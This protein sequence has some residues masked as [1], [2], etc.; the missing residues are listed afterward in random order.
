MAV[1][2]AVP[3]GFPDLD[4]S[5]PGGGWPR[6]GL[7]EIL[8][9]HL[10]IGE[11]YLLLP[12]LARLTHQPSARW[13]AWIAPPFQPFA[14]AL[15]AHGLK[16]ER[17]LIAR[18]DSPESSTRPDSRSSKT[19][20]D[21]YTPSQAHTA[22]RDTSERPHSPLWAFEQALGSNACDVGLTWLQR[23]HPREIRRLQ[24]AAERGRS[25]GFLFRSASAAQEASSAALRVLLQ[26][27]AQGACITLLKSRGGLRGAINVS[28][29]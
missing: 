21:S 8:T 11:L 29:T 5:L 20:A 16:L 6:V 4:R 24:L 3:T 13:C 12:A 26:P 22:S 15:T 23:A 25:L 27:T 17:L 2:D 10:G 1:V 14:P 18:W 9:P 28:W 7:V 19:H